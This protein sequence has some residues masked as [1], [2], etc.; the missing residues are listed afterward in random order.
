MDGVQIDSF[1]QKS[2]IK[3]FENSTFILHLIDSRKLLRYKTPA[4]WIIRQMK[5]RNEECSRDPFHPAAYW[6]PPEP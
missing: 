6:A 2:E 5:R 1:F 4:T 3:P